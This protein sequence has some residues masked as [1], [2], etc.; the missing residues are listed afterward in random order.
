MRKKKQTFEGMQFPIV[1]NVNARTIA[2]DIK[3]FDP[4]NPQ[5]VADWDEQQKKMWLHIKE[6]FDAKGIPMPTVV[7]DHTKGP[8]TYGIKTVD[9]NGNTLHSQF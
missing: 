8:I 1:K 2:Q 3:G 4:G 6:Q 9:E 7:I 5:D